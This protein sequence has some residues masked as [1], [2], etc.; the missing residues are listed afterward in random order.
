MVLERIIDNEKTIAIIIRGKDW[1]PQL[2]F[3]TSDSDFQQVGIWGYDKGKILLPHIHLETKKEA[4]RSQEVI[5]IRR[6][7]LK[8]DLF[9]ENEKLFKSV[10][11]IEG[12]TMILLAG[13]HGYEILENNTQVLEVKNGPFMGVEKERKRIEL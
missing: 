12:D 8:A 9:N 5:F 13:G 7:R 1:V 11:L 6:G 3:I 2:N 10:E 4:A